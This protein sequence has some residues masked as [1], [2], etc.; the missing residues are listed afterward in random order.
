[1]HSHVVAYVPSNV[2]KDIMTQYDP[3]ERIGKWIVIFLE[4]DMD[5]KPRKMIKGQGL[6]KL[7]TR[8]NYDM[9]GDNFSCG[10]VKK[11]KTRNNATSIPEVS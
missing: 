10:S 7:M 9:F 1:L 11:F 4:Y 3:E 8:S 2:V 6:S 5:I